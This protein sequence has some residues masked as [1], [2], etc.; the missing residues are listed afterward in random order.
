MREPM[1]AAILEASHKEPGCTF[2]NPLPAIHKKRG[3]NQPDKPG[4]E[5]FIAASVLPDFC[6]GGKC[7]GYHCTPAR[8]YPE[9][10]SESMT[11]PM[12]KIRIAAAVSY[13]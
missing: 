11:I 5:L 9:I 4:K 6:S 2:R 10:Y 8:I 13:S 3:T 7:F 1:S 12:I